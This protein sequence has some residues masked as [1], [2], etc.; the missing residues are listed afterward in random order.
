MYFYFTIVVIVITVK[1]ITAG[2]NLRAYDAIALMSFAIQK[3]YGKYKLSV[4]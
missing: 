3:S 2:R 4:L 1:E